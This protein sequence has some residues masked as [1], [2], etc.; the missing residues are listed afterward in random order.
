MSTATGSRVPAGEERIVAIGDLNGAAD[1]LWDILIGTEVI[2]REGQWIGG[3]THVIQVGD[4]FNRGSGA[5]AAF[6]LLLALD[7]PARAAGGRVSVL[8]GNHEAMTALRNEAYVNEEEYLSFATP[9]QREAWPRRVSRARQRLYHSHSAT[10]PIKPLEPRLELWKMENVPGR[11][12]MRRELGAHGRLGKVIRKL[13][14][15]IRAR[16]AAFVHAGLSP[17]WAGYGIDGLNEQARLAW[18]KAPAFYLGVPRDSLLRSGDGPLWNRALT[19]ANESE[20]RAEF[21]LVLASLG[22]ER[23]VV[24]HTR[25]EQ[26][27][28]GERGRLHTR[29]EDRLVCLDVGISSGASSP[30]A[31]LIMDARGGHEWSPAGRRPLWVERLGALSAT[32]KAPPAV[33]GQASV[34]APA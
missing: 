33:R 28:G 2:D 13:P 23:L 3:S 15:A 27:A 30:R 19:L 34:R 7:R 18:R 8:L 5:R 20:V 24:G 32:P 4:I 10:G 25:T 1:A 6:E 11:L 9:E 26:V 17:S 22:V 14:I 16:R 29:F 31:A 12:A 21:E